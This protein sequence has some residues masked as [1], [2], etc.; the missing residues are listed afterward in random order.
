[1]GQI[2]S[3]GVITLF[4]IFHTEPPQLA[5][6]FNEVVTCAFQVTNTFFEIN[7]FT[8]P[9]PKASLPK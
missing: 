1:M 9:T 3:L 4:E 7:A 8:S 6:V 5:Q 2:M